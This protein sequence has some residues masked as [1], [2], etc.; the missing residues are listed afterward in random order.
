M[1]RRQNICQILLARQKRKSFLHRIMTGDEKWI[2][3]QNPKRKKSWVD[4]AQP[5]ISSSRSNCF[6]RKT[7]L[8]VWWDQE[9]VVYY[10]LLKPGE[11]VNAH[12]YHQQLIKLHRALRE[13]R[14]HYRKRH[15]KLIFLHDNVPSHTI[16]IQNYLETLNWEV[17]PHPTRPGT[18]GL[19]PVFV[20]GSRAH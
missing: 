9:G 10:E 6:G 14:P 13:K 1:E 17:L 8:C 3:F 20:D 12:H 7:M 18:F 19:S 2:Y 16:M 15:D 5:S 11:T 4:P